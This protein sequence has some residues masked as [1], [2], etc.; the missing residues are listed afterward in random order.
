[1]NKSAKLIAAVALVG[2]VALTGCSKADRGA[3]QVE[4][5]AV[6]AATSEAAEAVAPSAPETPDAAVLNAQ[7]G[8]AVDPNS[9]ISEKINAVQGGEQAPEIFETMTKSQQES[10]ATFTVV[11]PIL[12]GFTNDSVLATVEFSLPGRA[13]QAIDNVTFVWED[14]R[15]KLSQ[16]WACTLITKTV[17]ESQV[18]AVCKALAAGAAADA[19]APTTAAQ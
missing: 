4:T 3:D 13:P 17:D 6:A 10:G 8:T 12:P 14:G 15:W 19:T 7:L 9:P 16:D 1:M 18:P 5:S 2:T 11:D